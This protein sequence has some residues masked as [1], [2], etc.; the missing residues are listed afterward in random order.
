MTS[1]SHEQP[2]CAVAIAQIQDCREIAEHYLTQALIAKAAELSPERQQQY[3]TGRIL[4]ASLLAKT[5]AITTLPEI[6][7]SSNGRP[8]F[9]D[10][11]LPDFNISHSGNVIMVAVAQHC[12]VG[13]DLELKR[14]RKKLLQLAKY[15]FSQAEYD[16]LSQLSDDAFEPAFWQL[17]TIRESILKLSGKGVWQ[18]K[19]MR[20]EPQQRQLFAQFNPQLNCWSCQQDPLFWAVTTNTELKK[21]H[22][23]LW[24]APV[25]LSSLIRQ[26]LPELTHFRSVD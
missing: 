20:V 23:S 25:G 9:T 4:L 8:S 1:H 5:L 11:Q 15:S 16:W 17:W 21:D 18:M 19:E 24:Q 2:R 7:V 22:I 14:P 6:I 26:P 12:Q 13:I 10:P 3:L